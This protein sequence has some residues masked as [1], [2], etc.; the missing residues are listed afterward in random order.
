LGEGQG[1]RLKPVPLDFRLPYLLLIKPGFSINTGS[2]YSTCTPEGPSLQPMEQIVRSW[3]EGASAGFPEMWGYNSFYESK[4]P[5]F[6]ALEGIRESC[7]SNGAEGVYLSGSGSAMVAWSWDD[8]AISG[9]QQE[10]QRQQLWSK[11][12]EPC[13]DGVLVSRC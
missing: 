6:R 9:L 8:A 11:R 3:S 12:V 1:E 4:L 10:M 5:H 13:E 2:A 7:I